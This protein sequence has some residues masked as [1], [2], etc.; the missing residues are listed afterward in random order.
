MSLCVPVSVKARL[1]INSSKSL[2]AKSFSF[3]AAS[4]ALSNLQALGAFCF[5]ATH[6]NYLINDLKREISVAGTSNV[7]VAVFIIVSP[8]LGANIRV[9]R[10]TSRMYTNV[11]I[12]MQQD[13][14]TTQPSSTTSSKFLLIVSVAPL[15]YLISLPMTAFLPL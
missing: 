13:H 5:L 1:F 8:F 4:N 10:E 11:S 12:F 15:I 2:V 6:P 9:F 7:Y 3:F 14:S